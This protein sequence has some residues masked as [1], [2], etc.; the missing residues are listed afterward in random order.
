[1]HIRWQK[2]LR[3]ATIRAEGLL[4]VGLFSITMWGMLTNFGNALNRGFS[5]FGGVIMQYYPNFQRLHMS[6]FRTKGA[7][8]A[9]VIRDYARLPEIQSL[10][11][12]GF[13]AMET[14]CSIHSYDAP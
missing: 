11:N 13:P 5:I 1:M 6:G 10:N 4:C 9:C 7:Q 3:F 14:C 8:G 12:H 2:N